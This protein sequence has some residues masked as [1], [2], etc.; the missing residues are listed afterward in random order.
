MRKILILIT[1]FTLCGCPLIAGTIDSVGKLGIT[2]QDR[3][4]LLPDSVKKFYEA[5]YWGNST[6]ASRFII[7]SERERLKDFLKVSPDKIR[8]VE[9]R[10]EDI[11][12]APDARSATVT[13]KVKYFEV[14]YYIV[15]DRMDTQDWEFTMSDGW[16]IK[17]ISYK[18]QDH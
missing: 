1:L 18:M 9:S 8:F 12:F 5:C 17:N 6:A 4:K 13:S 11:L 14:P 16:K 15:R 3:Q 10:I 2:E 7:D